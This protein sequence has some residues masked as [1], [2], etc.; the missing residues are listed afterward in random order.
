MKVNIL[1]NWNE[2]HETRRT[3]NLSDG[4]SRIYSHFDILRE[5]ENEI[6][7]L[8]KQ[9]ITTLNTNEFQRQSNSIQITELKVNKFFDSKF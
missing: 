5:R 1:K 6:S 7:D 9:Q 4:V 2:K 3:S 8:K